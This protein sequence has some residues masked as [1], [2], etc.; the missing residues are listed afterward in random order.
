MQFDYLAR[1]VFIATYTQVCQVGIACGD[2]SGIEEERES[3]HY[4][5]FCF[6]RISKQGTPAVCAL[7]QIVS[8][9]ISYCKTIELVFLSS[10][11]K[12]Y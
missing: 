11:I 2:Y 5:K 8:V 10:F 6:P 9:G 7:V 1:E 3:V 4:V 12:S